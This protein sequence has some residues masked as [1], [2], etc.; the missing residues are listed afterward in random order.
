MSQHVEMD[1]DCEDEEILEDD[2]EGFEDDEHGLE[3]PPGQL[4]SSFV[5]GSRI[6]RKTINLDRSRKH[7]LVLVP[8]CRKLPKLTV[9]S[10]KY[11]NSVFLEEFK[12]WNTIFV[13]FVRIQLYI[14]I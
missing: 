3:D 5:A 4:L 11:K 6:S 14:I 7:C 1:D 13:Y 9:T 12:G 10:H 2:E 8:N